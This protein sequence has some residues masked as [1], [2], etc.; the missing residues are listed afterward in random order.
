M[1][2]CIHHKNICIELYRYTCIYLYT[3]IYI[4][5]YIITTLSSLLRLLSVTGFDPYPQ[6][7]KLGRSR[8]SQIPR[9]IPTAGCRSRAEIENGISHGWI[10]FIPKEYIG[11]HAFPLQCTSL[12]IPNHSLP[13][14][15]VEVDSC[16]FHG[17]RC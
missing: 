12:L 3:C 7:I 14:I 13:F 5:I 10:V 1:Y 16:Q 17:K 9:Q 8:L 2:V 11:I 6:F 4:Y 15:Q